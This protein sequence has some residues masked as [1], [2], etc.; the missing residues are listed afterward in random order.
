MAHSEAKPRLAYIDIAKGFAMLCIIAGHFG[1]ITANRF[2]YTFH[3]PLFFLI[4]GYFLS[5]RLDLKTFIKKKVRQLIVPYYVAGFAI[6]MFAGI[7]NSLLGSDLQSVI[8]NTKSIF[9]ALLYGAG[10][11]HTEPMAIRQIGLLWFLWA[12]F[13]SLIIVRIALIFKRPGLIVAGVALVGIISAR[14]IWLPLS[15]QP[16]M[17]ASLFVYLGYWAKQNDI[18]SHTPSPS[19]VIGLT[20]L[21]AF[22]IAQ[23]IGIS[24]VGCDLGGNIARSAIS[25]A[26]SLGAS[27]L[28]I[29]IC[30]SVEKHLRPLARFLNMVGQAT[31]VVMCFHAVSDFTFPNYL[32]YEIMGQI[33]LSMPVMHVIVVAL[34]AGWALLGL[35]ITLK[36]PPLKKLFQVKKINPLPKSS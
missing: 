7:I 13:F 25:F 5:T 20:L 28:I 26:D 36:C 27:Y 14:F 12:L 33:G 17:L 22:C 24:V 8:G 11:P 6:I 19:L 3:V 35:A 10:T 18:L 21:W 34:N 30:K 1:I 31:L 4:S 32:L 23:Q 2:V 9:G 16:A 15:V 29:L